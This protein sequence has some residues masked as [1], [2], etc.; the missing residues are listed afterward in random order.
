MRPTDDE[1][2][3]YQLGRKRLMNYLI[4]PAS[5]N[6]NVYKCISNPKQYWQLRDI[7]WSLPPMLWGTSTYLCFSFLCLLCFTF[8]TFSFLFSICMF[9]NN[10][11]SLKR[12][13][14]LFSLFSFNLCLSNFFVLPNENIRN[15]KFVF[16]SVYLFDIFLF[17]WWLVLIDVV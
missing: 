5:D 15:G 8:N 1:D 12:H 14:Q 4:S 9:L 2:R 13:F 3:M 16:S 11:F 7:C 6:N 10:L 17:D